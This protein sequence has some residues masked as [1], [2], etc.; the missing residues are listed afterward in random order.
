MQ[1]D[2]TKCWKCGKFGTEKHHVIFGSANRKQ[3]DKYGL[4]VGLCYEH[5]RGTSG[6]HGRDGKH[7]NEDLKYYAQYAFEQKIG[8]REDFMKI[9]GKSYM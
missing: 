3:A 9:F 6:V 4:L 1:D 7:L 5:H 2:M 8:S